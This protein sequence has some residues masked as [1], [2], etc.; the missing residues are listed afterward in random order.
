M[1]AAEATKSAY[2]GGRWSPEVCL[3]WRPLE[4]RS[5]LTVEGGSWNH[6]VSLLWRPLE[7]RSL[8]TVQAAGATKSPYC[9][10]HWSREVALLWRPLEPHHRPE[11]GGEEICGLAHDDGKARQVPAVDDARTLHIV[12]CM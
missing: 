9:E 6:E 5:L 3:L 8:L 12:F 10:G 11:C 2:C 7:P 4:P 1:E